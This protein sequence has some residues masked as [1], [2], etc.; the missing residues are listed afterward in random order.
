MTTE[1]QPKPKAKRKRKSNNYLNNKDL[2]AEVIKSK[3][4]GEMS[5]KLAHMLTLLCARYA[6]KPNYANYS[7]NED[8]QAYA[9][10][11]L[12][13]TW[14]KF[15]PEKS[16]NPFAFYTQCIYHSFIQYLNLEKKQRDIRDMTL[17]EQGKNPSYT[18]QMS[19]QGSDDPS[20]MSD[21]FDY[22]S[23]EY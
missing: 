16:D 15:N 21:D 22:N 12:V 11:S 7:Y 1:E 17:I 23:Q 18:Y 9:M 14:Y 5:K 8:M 6:K 10:L 19:Q 4:E 2:L 3:E 20:R 13:K